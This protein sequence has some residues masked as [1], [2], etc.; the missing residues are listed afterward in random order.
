MTDAE[1][2]TLEQ[3]I[4]EGLEFVGYPGAWDPAEYCPQ[5]HPNDFGDEDRRAPIGAPCGWCGAKY[6]LRIVKQAPDPEEWE[7][8]KVGWA[9]WDVEMADPQAHPEWRIGKAP[10]RWTQDLPS[11]LAALEWLWRERAWQWDLHATIQDGPGGSK[12]WVAHVWAPHRTG[13][14]VGPPDLT[15]PEVLAQALVQV[16]WEGQVA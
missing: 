8:A 12:E 6:M 3:W 15:A 14:Q 5:G 1:R 2:T 7:A 13:F 16:F 4:S 9:L 10:K 11:L